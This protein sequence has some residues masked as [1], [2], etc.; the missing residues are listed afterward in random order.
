[1]FAV[2]LVMFVAV[3]SLAEDFDKVQYFKKATPG[4]K[5]KS[6][7]VKG[8]LRVDGTSK[9]IHFLNKDGSAALVIKPE[10]IKSII[11]ERT[12][13]PRYAAGLLL[14]WPLLF[15]K[16]KSHYLTIQ[17]GDETG[18]GEYAIFK[19]DKSNYRDALATIEAKTGKKIERSEE[20]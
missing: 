16:S 12:A 11:Y 6:D 19:L 17:Y 3:A 18:T 9:E 8:A 13:K 2:L 1:M 7:P 4:E 5:K 20:S 14:A 15:T 10:Q